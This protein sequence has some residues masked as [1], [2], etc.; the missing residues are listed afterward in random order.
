M[1]N[2]F[3]AMKEDVKNA[4]VENYNDSDWRGLRDEFEER[5]NDDLW[6]DDAVT[7][8]ASGSYF[9]NTWRAREAVQDDGMDYF[10]EACSDFGITSEEVGEHFIN[11]DWEYIDVTIRC[12]LLNQVIH[13]VLDEMEESG[14]FDEPED[15]AE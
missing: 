11:E 5:L 10:R 9:C 2:Y 12:Y 8:N 15:D 6:I 13:N 1:Y 3:E 4:I 14:A 7:G